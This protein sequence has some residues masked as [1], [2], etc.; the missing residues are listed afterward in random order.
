MDKLQAWWDFFDGKKTAIGSAFQ[1]A[2]HLLE[3]YPQTAVAGSICSEIGF[4]LTAG[5]LLHKGYKAAT[6]KE[7]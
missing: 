3:K 5:G 2:G 7:G 1:L 4:Y 6:T